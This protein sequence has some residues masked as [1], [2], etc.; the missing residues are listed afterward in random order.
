MKKIKLKING[1][2]TEADD[3][4]TLLNVADKMG[5]K[6]PTLCHH[7]IVEPYGVCRICTVE[8][9]IRNRT[10]M[11]TACNYPVTDGI[12]V[13]TESERVK[14]NRRMIL[15]WMLARCGDVKVLNDL[16]EEYGVTAPRFGR[17]TDKC[18]L[19]GLC[20][21]VCQDLVKADV[22]GFYERGT[23]RQ[24]STA[25]D[26]P[27]E[28]CITCGACAYVCPTGCIEI[29]DENGEKPLYSDLFLGPARPVSIPTMQAVPNVPAIDSETCIHFK[30]GGCGTCASVCEPQAINYDMKEEVVEV[31]AGNIIVATG[32]DLFEPEEMMQY[33]YGKLENVFTG[34]EVEALCNATGPTGGEVLLR[35]GTKPKAV[36]VLHC[37]GS[38]DKN[39]HEYCSRVCCMSSMKFS[40]LIHERTGAT[41]YEFYIDMRAYGKGYEEF[42]NK[43]LDEGIIFIRGKVA[44]ITDV[45]EVES[46]EGRLVVKVEDTLVGRFMRIPVDMVVLNTALQARKDA[47]EIA[48]KVSISVGKDGFFI[49]KHPKLDPVAT[50]TDGIYIAGCCQG[51][52]DIPDTVAQGSAAAARVLSLVS[53]GR[54]EIEAITSH[55]IEELCSGCRI[56]N[57]LCAYSAISFDPDKKVSVIQEALCKGCG[58]CVA[59]C[60]SEAIIANHFTQEQIL[61]E[62]SGVLK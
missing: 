4:A 56:C 59:A 7:P 36:A 43:L 55:V 14:R 16:A 30:T 17:G 62:I 24:V 35:D 39:H 57:S 41:V 20:V 22:L 1:R 23:T 60:P 10:R 29:F 27:S 5:I 28:F 49:E 58:T 50:S 34:I 12:E 52:K 44:E 33:G 8:V 13:F 11:V 15:E 31:P 3:R 18:I 47:Q 19:C 46:E 32:F 37:I 54:V 61:S 53:K 45:P 40:H 2:E 25:Y 48:R 21:R 38:R 9:R 26:K 6:I 51:P 42:Y